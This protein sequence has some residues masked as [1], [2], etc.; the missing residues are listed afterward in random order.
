MSAFVPLEEAGPTCGPKATTLGRLLR[1]GFDV[2]DGVVLPRADVVGWEADVPRVLA[3][4]GGEK[5]AVRSSATGED[6]SVAS[7]AGQLESRLQVPAE[8]VADEIRRTSTQRARGELYAS[9]VGQTLGNVSVIVQRMLSPLVA[10]VAFT[11]H[12]VTGRCVVVIEAVHGLGDTL[13]DGTTTP[14]RREIAADDAESVFGPKVLATVQAAAVARA[15]GNVEAV[16]GGGQDVEWAITPDG[17]V[18]ILQ[19]RPITAVAR[20]IQPDSP[21]RPV[22]ENFV[23]TGTPASPG[24]ARGRLLI[25]SGLDDFGRFDRGDVLVCRATSPGMDPTARSR[26]GGRHRAGRSP[27]P[28]GDRC[29]RAANPRHH[30]RPSGHSSV[31]QVGRRR[32]R[33]RRNHHD[34]RRILT[35]APHYRQVMHGG[36]C[37]RVRRHVWHQHTRRRLFRCRPRSHS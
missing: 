25:I 16:L 3:D 8:R 5:F 4:L 20:S 2:P 13:V 33:D 29:P 19:S 12:P 32:R 30:R 21:V 27:G 37:A 15:A 35:P 28:R 17:R 23:A 11:R 26:S 9:V 18:W 22:G 24:V 1:A 34:R 36:S 14:Q 10:G 6:G 7:F 31:R